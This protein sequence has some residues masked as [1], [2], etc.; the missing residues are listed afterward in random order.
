MG[1]FD[2]EWTDKEIRQLGHDMNVA[3]AKVLAKHDF[4]VEEIKIILGLP[5]SLIQQMLKK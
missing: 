4:T 5:E 1:A 2:K 3:K